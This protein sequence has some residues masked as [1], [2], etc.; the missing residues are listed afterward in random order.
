MITVRI[1]SLDVNAI[2]VIKP[3]PI[4][5]ISSRRSPATVL[6]A[7][8]ACAALARGAATKSASPRGIFDFVQWPQVSA[9]SRPLQDN[10]RLKLG[11]HARN[12][13]SATADRGDPRQ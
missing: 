7:Q 13:R 3:L 6:N 2:R 1:S 5:W 8:A 12:C 10:T 4:N 9:R 11:W